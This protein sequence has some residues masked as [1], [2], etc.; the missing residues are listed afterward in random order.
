MLRPLMARSLPIM[1]AEVRKRNLRLSL[2]NC[3]YSADANCKMTS[4]I[5]QQISCCCHI[6]GKNI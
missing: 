3:G 1:A 6:K 4:C 2:Y 5:N